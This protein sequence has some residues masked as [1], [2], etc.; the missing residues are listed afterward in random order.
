MSVCVFIHQLQAKIDDFDSRSEEI[1]AKFVSGE[2]SNVETITKVIQY[3][4]IVIIITKC[5]VV[6]VGVV[7]V[8]VVVA[9]VVVFSFFCVIFIFVLFL[10][11][12]LCGL[13]TLVVLGRQESVPFSTCEVSI[14]PC[15]R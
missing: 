12:L 8:V 13:G 6:V 4:V 7:V 2:M 10:W 9:V 11:V 14:A 3:R 5:F 15:L 1:A